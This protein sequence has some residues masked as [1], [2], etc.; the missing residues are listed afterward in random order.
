MFKAL[1]N[2]FTELVSDSINVKTVDVDTIHLAMA[3]LL[4]EVANADYEQ[5]PREEAAKLHLLQQL[6]DIGP[7]K[8]VELLERAKAYCKRAVSV[9]E[10]TSKLRD[11][12]Y[13]HRI[14]LIEAMWQV[15][16]ADGEIDRHEEA[17]IRK[18]ADLTYV[19]HKDFI[20]AKHAAEMHS[21]EI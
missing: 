15:A 18:V 6:F 2:L 1:H 9:Y 3:S 12:D 11:S 17:L 20:R 10:F 5:D 4:C 16:Y 7:Q 19:E 21:K 14:V 13:Q 8:A